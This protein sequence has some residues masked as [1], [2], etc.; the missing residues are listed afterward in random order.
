MHD[1]TPDLWRHVPFVL[2]S[3]YQSLEPSVT[4][5]TCQPQAQLAQWNALSHPDYQSARPSVGN[6]FWFAPVGGLLRM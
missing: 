1:N 6:S 4:V 3:G 2:S 5:C